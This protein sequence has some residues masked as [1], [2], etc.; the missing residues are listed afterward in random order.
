MQACSVY[1]LKLEGVS[2]AFKEDFCAGCVD[3]AVEAVE[4]VEVMYQV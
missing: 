1:A 4:A 3:G 2:V